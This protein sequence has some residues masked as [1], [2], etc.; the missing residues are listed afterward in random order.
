MGYQERDISHVKHE[1]HINGFVLD[2]VWV[3]EGGDIVKYNLGKSQS[4]EA[5]PLAFEEFDPDVR[6]AARTRSLAKLSLVSAYVDSNPSDDVAGSHD[7]VDP[8]IAAGDGLY[9][10]S[11]YDAE[12]AEFRRLNAALQQEVTDAIAANDTWTPITAST[13]LVAYSFTTTKNVHVLVFRGADNTLDVVDVSAITIPFLSSGLAKE[14]SRE[15]WITDAGLA[16][17]DTQQA[18]YNRSTENDR[19]VLHTQG[20]IAVVGLLSSMQPTLVPAGVTPVVQQVALAWIGYVR[21]LSGAKAAITGHS[22]GGARAAIAAITI[23]EKKAYT[24]QTITFGSVGSSCWPRSNYFGLAFVN[25]T[26]DMSHIT[27]YVHPLDTY[28]NTYGREVG[29][30][31]WVGKTNIM[32]SKAKKYCENVSAL[33]PAYLSRIRAAKVIQAYVVTTRTQIA[34]G[35]AYAQATGNTALLTQLV[36]KN[37]TF[38]GL[39]EEIPGFTEWI[40]GTEN[41]DDISHS[42]C[43]YFTHN[44]LALYQMVVAELKDNGETASGCTYYK[45][46][47]YGGEQ[48]PYNYPPANDDDDDFWRKPGGPVFGVFIVITFFAMIAAMVKCATNDSDAESEFGDA[49]VNQDVDLE[50]EE[51]QEE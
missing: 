9:D 50:Q 38:E 17:T 30:S 39:V 23:K 33:D 46:V 18:N 3:M 25:G 24:V 27:E 20:K 42:Q 6:S 41:A 26:T 48:C 29:M 10:T 45:A 7:V 22:L 13:A 35:I 34:Q 11:S 40:N 43:R 16:W 31:C 32:E 12:M 49:E 2:H 51:K 14:K 15:A 21:S 19:Y 8:I 1:K 36:I 4:R 37:A 44:Q 28:G 5:R 47:P